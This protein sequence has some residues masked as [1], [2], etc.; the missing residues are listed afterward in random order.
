M[1]KFFLSL[2]IALVC[3]LSF[4]QT[5]KTSKND[6]AA[7]ALLDKVAAKYKSFAS[8]EMTFTLNIQSVEDK[9]NETMTGSAWIRGEK[10]RVTTN[11]V[12]I[13]C[14]NVKRW[15]YLKE[16]NEVQINFYEPEEDN[17]ESPAQLFTLYKKNF[18]YR[19]IAD[20]KV[21]GKVVKVVEL[22]PTKLENSTYS[23]VHLYIDPASNNIVQAKVFNKDKVTY[24]WKITKFT[25]NAK[26]DDAKFVFDISKYPKVHVED[27]TK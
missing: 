14:D 4:A 22:T 7:Q 24:T 18:Y 13:V 26:I 1:S 3:T 5:S 23:R 16:N 25:P 27:M 11:T 2:C 9:L 6:P 19:M 8:L 17:I 20:D 10:Y 15:T 21:D 12:D